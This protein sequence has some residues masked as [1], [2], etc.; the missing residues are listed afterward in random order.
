MS[1]FVFVCAIIVDAIVGDPR[2]IPHPVVWI[3]KLISYFEKIWRKTWNALHPIVFGTVTTVI[4]V[5]GTG[6]LMWTGLNILGE[7]SL[8]LR[9]G[10]EIW[11]LSTTFAFRSLLEASFDVY[12]PLKKGNMENARKYVG[13]IVGRDTNKMDE[14]EVTR[15]TIETVSENLTDGII[16]PLF[17]A[18]IGGLPLAMMYKAVNTLDSMIGHRNERYEKFGK[19][20]A[21]LDD[22]CNY[23][24]ARISFVF[25]FIAAFLLRFNYINVWKYGMQDAKKHP[26]PNSGWTESAFAY[27][28]DVQLGGWN[29]YGGVRQFRAYMGLPIQEL[30]LQ[31]IEQSN[32]LMTIAYCLSIGVFLIVN[33]IFFL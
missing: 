14:K 12:V 24:P 33:Y 2:T 1:F 26:S 29:V 9:Y 3:G 13:W 17:Y 32:T 15:A 25:V 11:L 22:V 4:V 10:V 18:M 6:I 28:L 16:A 27:A 21:K 19:C 30:S 8:P 5:L 23:I 7:I 31:K 20:A